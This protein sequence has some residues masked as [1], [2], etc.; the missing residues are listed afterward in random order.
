M[1][2][3][4]GLESGKNSKDKSKLQ[5]PKLSPYLLSLNIVEKVT[6][7][8]VARKQRKVVLFYT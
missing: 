3:S 8:E 2:W 4:G 5:G 7:D 6:V 1:G